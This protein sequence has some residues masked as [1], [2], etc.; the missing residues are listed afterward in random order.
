[1]N[2]KPAANRMSAPPAHP[3]GASR[4]AS[5]ENMLVAMKPTRINT[6]I[7]TMT[8]S[9]LPTT[10]EPRKLMPTNSRMIPAARRRDTDELV[11]SGRNVIA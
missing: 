7:A 9:A 8:D 3:D 4:P 2:K 6:L 1:M 11:S 5:T 10:A